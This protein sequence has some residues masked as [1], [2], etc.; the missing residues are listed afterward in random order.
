MKKQELARKRF[1]KV[2]FYEKREKRKELGEE[3]LIY[4]EDKET[5]KV[6]TK[7]EKFD[8]YWNEYSKYNLDSLCA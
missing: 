4:D 8:L 1:A 7:R 6:F 3:D 5:K 2:R